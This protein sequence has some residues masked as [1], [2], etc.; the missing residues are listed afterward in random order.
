LTAVEDEIVDI[1]VEVMVAEEVVGRCS[2]EDCRLAGLACKHSHFVVGEV[3][4]W[5]GDVAAVS[6]SSSFG[7]LYFVTMAVIPCMAE[8]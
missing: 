2:L 7:G 6:D 3:E 1:G 5:N 8:A 4:E